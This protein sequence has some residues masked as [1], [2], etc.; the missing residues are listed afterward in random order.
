MYSRF[1]LHSISENQ[2]NDVLKWTYNSLSKGGYFFIEVRGQ[3]NE[4]YRKGTPVPNERDA[5]IYE[6]HYRRFINNERFCSKLHDIGFHIV[7]NEE[8]KGFSPYNNDDQTFMR[9]IC[10]KI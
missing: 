7:L 5:Y 2:E 3:K 9:L 6:D 1:T 4:I 10:K 8:K